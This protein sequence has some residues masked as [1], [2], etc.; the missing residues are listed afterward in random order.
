MAEG[1]NVVEFMITQK[2][3]MTIMMLFL[4]GRQAGVKSGVW[5]KMTYI[6]CSVPESVVNN[7]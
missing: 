4:T 6:S 3:G 5:L 2:Q 1:S 7:V